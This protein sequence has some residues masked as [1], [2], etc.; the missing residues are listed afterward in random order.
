MLEKLNYLGKIMPATYSYDLRQKVI[1]AIDDGVSI[2]QKVLYLK[3]VVI[4]SI[5]SYI[6][7]KPGI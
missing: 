3:L 6:E 2:I 5:L 7:E 1:N 4:P